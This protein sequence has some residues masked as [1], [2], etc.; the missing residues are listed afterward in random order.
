M[1]QSTGSTTDINPGTRR[2]IIYNTITVFR[3]KIVLAL[4]STADL[5]LAG[6]TDIKQ[7]LL[8]PPPGFPNH[9]AVLKKLDEVLTSV[10][11]PDMEAFQL[12]AYCTSDGG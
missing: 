9:V 12:R 1:F 6:I 8:K 3:T 4:V 5:V 2:N 10:T 7:I 11:V